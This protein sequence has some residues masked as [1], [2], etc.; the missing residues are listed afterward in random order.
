MIEEKFPKSIL[1]KG[2]IS[3][4]EYGWKL[5]DIPEVIEEARKLNLGIVGGQIQYIFTDGTCELYWINDDPKE[6]N[7]N[8]TWTDY[9]NRSCNEFINIFKSKIL[10]TDI[11][12]EAVESFE[13]LKD[14]V[15]NGININEYKYFILYFNSLENQT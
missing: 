8:E 12:K 14:K 9:V 13:I 7:I 6:K 5:D 4:K 15:K 3:G 10:K 11:H 1:T 2:I